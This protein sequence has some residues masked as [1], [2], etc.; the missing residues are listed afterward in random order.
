MPTTPRRLLLLALALGA[1]ALLVAAQDPRPAPATEDPPKPRV[2][3][4]IYANVAC[5]I[6]GKPISTRLH[7]DTPMGR[8]WVCCKGCDEDILLFVEDAHR[9]AYPNV[10]R[11]ENET[12]P[13]SRKP[14]PEEEAPRLVL[15]GFDLA[16]CCEGCIPK[17]RE[18]SQ[19]LLARLNEPELVDLGNGTCPVSGEP[20]D[21]R[22]FAVI[23]TTIVRLARPRLVTAV[24]DEPDK[25]LE[26]ARELRA[27]ELERERKERE[28]QDGPAGGDSGDSRDGASREGASRDGDSRHRGAEGGR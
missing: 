9:T 15:Q 26:R 7:V 23:D 21:P 13:V 24:E 3:V 4:P 1:P 11:L 27:E 8:F 25:V 19:V 12:C 18:D 22:T 6:M 28:Q 16:L 5:P 10:E 20:V 2:R 14:I 17:A